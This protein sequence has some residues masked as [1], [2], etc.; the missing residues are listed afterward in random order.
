MAESGFESTSFDVP[1]Y[2][3]TVHDGFGAVAAGVVVRQARTGARE[4]KRETTRSSE[5]CPSRSELFGDDLG[6]MSYEPTTTRWLDGRKVGDDGK[7]FVRSRL[8]GRDF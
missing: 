3:Q 8:V 2:P 5:P 7:E 1:E 4:G 6:S